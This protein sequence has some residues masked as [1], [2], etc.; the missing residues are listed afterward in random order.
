MLHRIYNNEIYCKK[1]FPVKA[2]DVIIFII[3]IITWLQM[4]IYENT[5]YISFEC[6]RSIVN[7]VKLHKK[8]RR[9]YIP[10]KCNYKN[11][12]YI[13]VL[14]VLLDHYPILWAQS[15]LVEQKQIVH[16]DH[17]DL[18]S[19]TTSSRIV[20]MSFHIYLIFNEAVNTHRVWNIRRLGI[21]L[22]CH[23]VFPFVMDEKQLC[24]VL[25]LYNVLNLWLHFF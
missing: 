13:R 15:L 21:D 11:N 7:L 3:I 14:W 12:A 2:N 22:K 19:C 18:S 5:F 24:S 23:C 1:N 25:W 10:T 16:N 20:Y 8:K 4:V 6:Q 9:R 17:K